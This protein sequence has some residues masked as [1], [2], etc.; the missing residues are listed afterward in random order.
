ML[1]ESPDRGQDAGRYRLS[2][3]IVLLSSDPME[4][5]GCGGAGKK[6]LFYT[7]EECGAEAQRGT[8]KQ[9]PRLQAAASLRPPCG[10]QE[11]SRPAFSSSSVTF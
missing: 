3:P 9:E 2:S 5:R 4:W 10:H 6:Q 11:A 8:E 7:K 1:A